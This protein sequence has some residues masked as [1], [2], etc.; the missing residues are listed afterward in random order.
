M[1]TSIEAAL[2]GESDFIAMT[3]KVITEC[4]MSHLSEVLHDKMRINMHSNDK[5]DWIGICGVS[6]TLKTDVMMEAFTTWLRQ[7]FRQFADDISLMK[8]IAFRLQLHWISFP[9]GP[10][11]SKSTLVKIL[12]WGEI[13]KKPSYELVL[14]WLLTHICVT[15]L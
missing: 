3:M 7:Y 2:H 15:W 1:Y 5:K 6:H 11:D 14:T 10:I 4:P 13:G 12:A 8:M 9:N